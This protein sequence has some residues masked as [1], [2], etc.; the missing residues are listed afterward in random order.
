MMNGGHDQPLADDKVVCRV[1][2]ARRKAH[3]AQTQY[4]YPAEYTLLAATVC[5]PEHQMTE[6][7]ENEN[8]DQVE[9]EQSQP[10]FE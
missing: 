10:A 5:L 4:A 8:K 9:S 3:K 1:P 2:D 6:A 7:D